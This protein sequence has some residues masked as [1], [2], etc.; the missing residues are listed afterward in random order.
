MTRAVEDGPAL[1]DEKI[2]ELLFSSGL[3]QLK[4][5]THPVIS[6]FARNIGRAATL[7]RGRA[8]AILYKPRFNPSASTAV[9]SNGRSGAGRSVFR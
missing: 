3:S 4:G 9:S 1:S 2:R 7:V 8:S 6:Q 5:T